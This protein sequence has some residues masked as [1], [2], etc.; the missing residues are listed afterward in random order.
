MYRI[1]HVIA[2]ERDWHT[3][4]ER[5]FACGRKQTHRN[6]GKNIHQKSKSKILINRAVNAVAV[7]VARLRLYPLAAVIG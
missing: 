6:R 3:T 5:R 1:N 7:R 4:S 2:F